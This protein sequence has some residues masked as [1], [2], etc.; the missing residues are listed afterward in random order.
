MSKSSTGVV[1]FEGLEY[2]GRIPFRDATSSL[3]IE[4]KQCD[5]DNAVCGNPQECVLRRCLG[6]LFQIVVVGK[7]VVHIVMNGMSIRYSPSGGLKRAID[8]FDRTKGKG[9]NGQ[10][11]WLLKPGKYTLTPPVEKRGSRPNR[12]HLYGGN[13][14]KAQS[15]KSIMAAP[16]RCILQRKKAA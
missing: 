6:S 13:G 5:I 3:E 7:T 8:H 4:I 10:G 2:L 1:T 9:K 14:G 12:Q 15:L 11:I 16:T